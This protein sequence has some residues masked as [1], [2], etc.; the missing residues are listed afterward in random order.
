MGSRLKSIIA[1]RRMTLPDD[2]TPP[3]LA[4]RNKI[5]NLSDSRF[6]RVYMKAM[7]KQN[8]KRVK[9]FR[10]EIKKGRDTAIRSFASETL[11][12]IEGNLERARVVQRTLK[13]KAVKS[14]ASEKTH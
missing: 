10:S 3:D 9:R 6:D 11:P 8:G 14:S 5:E 13:G 2:L 7:V 1:G 4:L 12:V